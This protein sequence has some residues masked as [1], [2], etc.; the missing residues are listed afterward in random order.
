MYTQIYHLIKPLA[1]NFV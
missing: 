1:F